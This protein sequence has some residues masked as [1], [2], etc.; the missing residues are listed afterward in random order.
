MTRWWSE[1]GGEVKLFLGI[2]LTTIFVIWRFFDTGSGLRFWVNYNGF[3][4]ILDFCFT[5]LFT[6]LI[7]WTLSFI[8][9]FIPNMIISTFRFIKHEFKMNKLYEALT[10]LLFGGLSLGSL[11]GSLIV[12]SQIGING[13]WSFLVWTIVSFLLLKP[14]WKIREYLNPDWGRGA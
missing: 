4:T 1:Y 11:F 13:I 12:F 9:I 5:L 6:I 3:E 2:L 8:I 10:V 14:N 7:G